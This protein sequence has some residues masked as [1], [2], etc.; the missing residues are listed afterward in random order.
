MFTVSNH[1]ILEEFFLIPGIRLSYF[2]E[3]Y[4]WNLHLRLYY[5][6]FNILIE[7]HARRSQ[8]SRS[9][10]LKYAG[11]RALGVTSLRFR[12]SSCRVTITYAIKFQTD[13]SP[14]SAWSST[15]LMF[16]YHRGWKCRP[17]NP[18]RLRQSGSGKWLPVIDV[19]D[20]IASSCHTGA[21][22]GEFCNY[23]GKP[24]WCHFAQR[25]HDMRVD[26]NS[27]GDSHCPN[28]DL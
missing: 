19:R 23:V 15:S 3:H 14:F 11:N 12:F 1:I 10:S 9:V 2:K 27:L 17:R 8:I 18:S 16:L 21:K 26:I 5:S 28:K 25:F 7:D 13:L 24:L 20:R 22:S 4:P 6:Y